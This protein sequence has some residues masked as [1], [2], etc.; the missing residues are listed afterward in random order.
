MRRDRAVSDAGCTSCWLPSF[1]LDIRGLLAPLRR[2]Q[3]DPTLQVTPDGTVWRTSTT[4]DGAA[5]LALRR[6]ACG[7][8]RATAWGP[9]AGWMIDGV[10]SLL[11]A[12]FGV[13]RQRVAT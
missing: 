2:G 5:T 10:P 13:T 12:A 9:G 4:P 1:P 3:G 11:G 7:Q 8:V 6:L